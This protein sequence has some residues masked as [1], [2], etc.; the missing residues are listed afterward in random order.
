MTTWSQIKVKLRQLSQ[1]KQSC[2]N[3]L[4]KILMIPERQDSAAYC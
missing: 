1:I 4:S 3:E 2:A